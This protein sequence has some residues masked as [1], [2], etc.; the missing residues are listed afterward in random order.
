V[1]CNSF[2]NVYNL[3]S[4]AFQVRANYINVSACGCVR[5]TVSKSRTSPD[6]GPSKL[7]S[8]RPGEPTLIWPRPSNVHE[9]WHHV[10]K[11]VI[12]EDWSNDWKTWPLTPLFGPSHDP[13]EVELELTVAYEL[14][15]PI[16]PIMYS[17]RSRFCFVF[18]AGNYGGFYHWDD[19]AGTLHRIMVEPQTTVEEFSIGIKNWKING[20]RSKLVSRT[21]AG[22]K[23]FEKIRREQHERDRE[24]K[25]LGSVSRI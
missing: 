14:P 3:A 6:H 5:P 22:Q 18:Q 15:R 11:S 13:R 25:G 2:D 12:P 21:M 10:P 23:R 19:D 17:K 24:H 4:V 7:Q 9:T 8:T 20:P 16:K 1:G